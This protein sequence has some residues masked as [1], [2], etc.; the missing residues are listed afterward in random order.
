MKFFTAELPYQKYTAIILVPLLLIAVFLW[1]MQMTFEPL[2]GDLTRLGYLSEQDFGW[3]KEQPKISAEQLK[4]VPL[5]EADVLVLGDSFSAG[6]IWQTRLREHDLK[7]S[8]VSWK[9]KPCGDLGEALRNAG[10]KG[11]Y[12]IIESIENLFSERMATHCQKTEMELLTTKKMEFSVAAPHYN[13]ADLKN[14]TPLGG[15]WMIKAAFNKIWLTYTKIH[16]NDIVSLG[17]SRLAKVENGCVLFSHKVCEY[18]LFYYRDFGG[19]PFEYLDNVLAL[20]QSLVAQ[21][22]QPLWL[23]IPNK[24]T[25]YLPAEFS[26][27]LY[28]PETW[29][30]FEQHK[31]LL[32]PN[33]KHSFVE[34]SRIEQDFYRS[35]DTH[36]ST[37]GFLFLGDLVIEQLKP[38]N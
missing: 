37:T 3:Q 5:N 4:S 1:R 38:H 26:R 18:G 17:K 10:F 28:A 2:E 30:L 20:N 22:I 31:E 29:A 14:E 6:L 25:V 36:L 19:K 13:R 12:V 21:N 24:S 11:H 27:H 16:K 15:L 32:V 33:L 8:F 9:F 23:L 7:H 34:Q 35:N